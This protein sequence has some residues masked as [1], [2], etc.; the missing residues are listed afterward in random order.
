MNLNFQYF[1]I[2]Y[3]GPR[4]SNLQDSTVYTIC[5]IVTDIL[6]LDMLYKKQSLFSR[7]S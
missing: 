1:E 3:L 6:A 2:K 4:T 5:H 7:G